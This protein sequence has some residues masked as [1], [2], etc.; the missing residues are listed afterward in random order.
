[1][2]PSTSS[3][4]PTP[5]QE[6]PHV[7]PYEGA[8]LWCEPRQTYLCETSD[9]C[10]EWGGRQMKCVGVFRGEGRHC[11]ARHTHKEK[12]AWRSRLKTLVGQI[13]HRGKGCK[14]DHLFAYLSL[15]ALK[16]SS[17]RP[18]KRHRLN[19]D[20]QAN[21]RSYFHQAKHYGYSFER[22][23]GLV[24]IGDGA[25]PYYIQDLRWTTGLGWYGQN[26][27]LW[28]FVWDPK[29]PPEILCNE[30]I[31]TEVAL[32]RARRVVGKL[33]SGVD[34]DG[35]GER[36]Y[37][38]TSCDEEHCYPSWYDIH[39]ATQ[40]GSLCPSGEKSMAAFGRRAR[41][42]NLP[43]LERVTKPMLG[44]PIPRESQNERMSEL[45]SIMDDRSPI[46]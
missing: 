20:L 22:D 17:W 39:N 41:K 1:M 26:A 5:K 13:C 28:T 34:C 31:A 23:R 15:E 38:G 11:V 6:A 24:E 14:P 43:S 40:R 19:P 8:E 25:N 16:E 37:H 18:W 12:L 21:S 36:E 4:P 10:P 32:R 3:P 35:D 33:E 46:Q 44:T 2:A 29:A 45:I 27:A 42:N 7:D 30:V 9:D